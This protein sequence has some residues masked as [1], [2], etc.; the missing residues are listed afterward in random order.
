[1]RYF[2]WTSKKIYKVTDLIRPNKIIV[3]NHYA[4]LFLEETGYPASEIYLLGSLRYRKKSTNEISEFKIRT[5]ALIIA[6]LLDYEIDSSNLQINIAL[7]CENHFKNKVKFI[8]KNHPARISKKRNGIVFYSGKLDTLLLNVDFVFAGENT[9]SAVE[10]IER[11][12]PTVIL[13][14]AERLNISSVYKTQLSTQYVHNTKEMIETIVG[15][16]E[17]YVTYNT[18]QNF[19]FQDDNDLDGWLNIIDQSNIE[20]K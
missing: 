13:R 4:K 11:G 19:F 2:N 1:M 5:E 20:I 14:D 12:I 8:Y 10:S 18:K 6:V 3:N 17:N 7:K 15:M 9:A 16:I